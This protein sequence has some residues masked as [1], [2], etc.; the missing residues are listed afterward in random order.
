[1]RRTTIA[2]ACLVAG[3]SLPSSASAAHEQG[4]HDC[5]GAA[6]AAEAGPRLGQLVSPLAHGHRPFGGFISF[7]ARSCEE[8]FGEEGDLE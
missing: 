8:A 3:L 4:R 6:V 7:E 2:L 5:F 1:M